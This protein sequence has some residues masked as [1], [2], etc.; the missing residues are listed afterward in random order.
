MEAYVVRCWLRHI[1]IL[2]EMRAVLFPRMSY[3]D[4]EDCR[5]SLVLALDIN[6]ER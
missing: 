4:D 2:G 5:F 6:N 1:F 3:N